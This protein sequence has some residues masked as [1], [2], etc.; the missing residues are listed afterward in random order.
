MLKIQ[1]N[2]EKRGKIHAE[3]KEQFMQMKMESRLGLE[4]A[5]TSVPEGKL[6]FE[7][8]NLNIRFAL[9]ERNLWL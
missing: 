1:N 4:L 3:F 8:E 9:S 7:C 5:A 2:E 6:I